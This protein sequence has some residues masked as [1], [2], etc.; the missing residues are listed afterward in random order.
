MKSRS[1][2]DQT[3]LRLLLAVKGRADNL[4]L[5]QP[6]K[7]FTEAGIEL[8]NP[9]SIKELQS[10]L[11]SPDYDLIICDYQLL[12]ARTIAQLGKIREESIQTPLIVFVH[13]ADPDKFKQAQA[14]Q[15]LH[16]FVMTE[17]DT[18]GLHNLIQISLKHALLHRAQLPA[19]FPVSPDFGRSYAYHATIDKDGYL[20]TDWVSGSF[21]AVTGYSIDEVKRAGGWVSLVDKEDLPKIKTFVGNLIANKPASV[22]YRLISKT[23]SPVWLEGGGHPEW[24]D[25]EKRVCGISGGARDVTEREQLKLT[26]QTLNRQQMA[27][28]GMGE[29]TTR[30]TDLL[31]LLKQTALLVTQTLEAWICEIF[32][33]DKDN[34]QAVLQAATG[35]E[36]GMIG[37]L[38]LPVDKDNEL[39]FALHNNPRLLIHNLRQENRFKPSSHLRKQKALSGIC[40][41]VKADQDVFGFLAVYSNQLSAFNDNQLNFVQSI[42]TL[43]AAFFTQQSTEFRLRSTRDALVEQTQQL[44]GKPEDNLFLEKSNGQ[45][46]DISVIV[47]TAKELR[48]RDLILS[49]T[50]KITR[51]LIDTSDWRMAMN[52]V[53]A[54]LGQAANTSRAYLCSNHTDLTGDLLTSILYEW[55][56]TGVQARISQPAYQNMS[57]QHV[58]LSRFAEILD[59][60]GVIVGQVDEF[61]ESEQ[62]YFKKI[63]VKSTAIV[64]IFLENKWWGFLGFDACNT[65]RSWSTAEVDALR[66]AANMIS[67]VLERKHNDAA[68]HAVMEG[69][70]SK[71][72]EDYFRSLLKHLVGV[73]NADYCLLA[74]ATGN[75][76]F[77]VRT[78]LHNDEFLAPFEYR[79]EE[80]AFKSGTDEI[81]HYPSNV[82][83]AFP[84]NAWLSKRKIEGYLAIPVLDNQK[85]VLGHIAVMSTNRLDA[86]ILELQ[87]LK[88][89]AARVGVEMERQRMEK[90]NL[91]LARISLENPNMLVVADL[92][93][94]IVLSNPACAKMIEELGLADLDDLLP[95]PHQDLIKQVLK[96]KE[97]TVSAEKSIADYSFQWNYYLQSDLDRVHI[98]AIDMTQ[99]R[100][101]E[102][103]LRKDAFHDVLTG[104]PNRTFFNNLLTHAIERT[105]RRDDYTFAV[106]FLDLDR[107]KYINDSLGHA[108]G[109][110]FLEIVSQLLKNCLRPGDHIARFGGDEFAILLDSVTGDEEATNIATRIQNVLSKPIKLDQHESFTSASIGIALSNRGYTSPQDILRDADI[111]MYSAKQAGKARH[112]VFDSRMHD[113]MIHVLKLETDLRNALKNGELC[114]YYQPIYSIPQRSLAGFEA[115][116][117]WNHPGKGFLEPHDFIP[118]AEEMSIIRDIDYLVLNKAARQLKKWRKEFEH[119]KNIKM[120]INLSGIHFNNAAILAEIGHVLKD[121][122]LSNDSLQIELTEGVIMDNTGRSAEIFHV[123]SQLGVHI[124]IDDF[125]VGYS[126]LSRL[127]KLP[128]D[129]LKIDR[130]FVQ[131]MIIDSSSLNITRA[132]IDLAHD[133]DM[134]VIAEG[135][136]TQGQFQIL[137]RMGCHYAQGYYISKPL[138]TQEVETFLANP[139]SL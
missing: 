65:K 4:D 138:S 115:L 20:H 102:T 45:D 104:L 48:G 41:P 54:E 15:S 101:A 38:V 109:D 72:G 5:L 129:M 100:L 85:G 80:N 126:S 55:V 105:N 47:K 120:N 2:A 113:E 112:A 42:A 19:P 58:G 40:V 135:V 108:Y 139:P 95:E 57:L 53:L 32:T 62:A 64:P 133:L 88:I 82:H 44:R 90:E 34:H 86:D 76:H 27:I 59:R 68:L 14:L 132:I 74:E 92:E 83:Q 36:S 91:Q 97:Q 35:L 8:T 63:E 106:L 136:E 78:A 96:N 93:G 25:V 60:S 61:T 119:A 51:M 81:V 127:T 21:E 103:Q 79:Q 69:T 18:P 121:N 94:N 11:E 49:A 137:S 98:Y 17:L 39:A 50:A 116:V 114:V 67:S 26:L 111:A 110:K 87:I 37:K 33:L 56:N 134:E 9:R 75:N 77:K 28:V 1:A 52:E 70:V 71:T 10:A 117:R 99:Y 107:F 31:A 12:S 73:F 3:R 66:I 7:S 128:V 13:E 29:L 43:L 30:E 6:V 124:S 46:D 24:D 123:L 131:S 22:V 118:L 125:G 84:E 23:G 122:K 16:T 89:F 130:G